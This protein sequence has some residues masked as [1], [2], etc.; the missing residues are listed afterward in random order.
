[1]R[2]HLRRGPG[3]GMQGIEKEKESLVWEQPLDRKALDI[4]VATLPPGPYVPF[5]P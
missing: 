3:P 2:V 1:M 4:S 5:P